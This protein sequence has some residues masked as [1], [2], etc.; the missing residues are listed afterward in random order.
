MREALKHCIEGDT[1]SETASEQVM[2]E[3]M[4]GS[5]ESSQVA[6]LLT[7]LRM[8]GET[9]D[10][11]TGFVRSMRAHVKQIPHTFNHLLDT[12]GTGGDGASTFNI[13][14][15]SA[16]GISACDIKVAKHGNRSVS[17]TSGSADVLEALGIQVQTEPAEVE[18]ALSSQRLAFLFAPLYHPSM[19][20]VVA[21]RKELGFRTVFNLL[22]PLTN[23][24]GADR[25]VIGVFSKEYAEKMAEVLKRLGTKRALLVTGEDGLDEVTITGKTYITELNNGE[26]TN[27]TLQPEDVGANRAALADIQVESVA[28]SANLI[29][30]ALKNEAN[31]AVQQV[32]ALNMATALYIAGAAPTIKEGF[33]LANEKIAKQE[34]AEHFEQ[35]RTVKVGESNA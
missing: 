28:E 16:I 21:T 8:R 13:S 1:L 2:N 34:I 31:D 20:Y 29:E 15:A 30:R 5:T 12:C 11:M 4:T 32:L 10:E 3:I 6:S 19:K 14:T 23:P 17:S 22:G 35:L 25:Q 7:I 18:Q 27:Y 26:I 9:V 33:E 24:A